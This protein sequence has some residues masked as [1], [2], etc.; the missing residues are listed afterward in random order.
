MKLSGLW[1]FETRHYFSVIRVA[2]QSRTPTTAVASDCAFA[3][4]YL[5]GILLYYCK[6]STYTNRLFS[7][8][9]QSFVKKQFRN[10]KKY[11]YFRIGNF[12]L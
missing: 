6:L 3:C 8:K 2:T 10:M 4:C 12:K 7:P 5:G 9:K 11:P 1:V